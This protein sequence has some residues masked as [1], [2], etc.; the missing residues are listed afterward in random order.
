MEKTS[1]RNEYLTGT[2][3]F[4]VL[5]HPADAESNDNDSDVED[6]VS[7]QDDIV[8][9]KFPEELISLDD[10]FIAQDYKLKH[11]TRTQAYWDIRLVL[12]PKTG[13]EI[14]YHFRQS[15]AD[16]IGAVIRDKVILL[17]LYEM[18]DETPCLLLMCGEERSIITKVHQHDR[19]KIMHVVTI[20]EDDN[21]LSEYGPP[22]HAL[23]KTQ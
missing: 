19:C 5:F 23:T 8:T 1:R 16:F 12:H 2:T 13:K 21:L 22:G 10:M 17:D 18:K 6:R 4:K 11:E 15:T 14:A 7:S 9:C 20:T 3:T